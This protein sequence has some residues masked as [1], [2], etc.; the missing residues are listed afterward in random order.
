MAG[1][2]ASVPSPG[3]PPSLWAMTRGI[4]RPAVLP[5]PAMA[6]T[7]A[8]APGARATSAVRLLDPGAPLA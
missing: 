2:D 4:S 1:P 7:G 5:G 6:A 8:T 3:T